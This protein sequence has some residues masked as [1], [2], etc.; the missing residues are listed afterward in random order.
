MS[1]TWWP[2]Y[3]L[4]L[5]ICKDDPAINTINKVLEE[6]GDLPLED[7]YFREDSEFSD[8]KGAIVCRDSEES[9]LTFH[10]L[11]GGSMEP[12]W[13]LVIPSVHGPGPFEGVYTEESLVSEFRERIGEYLPE[14]FDYLGHIGM[15]SYC[16]FC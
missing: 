6:K 12:S 13:M 1:R 2:E 11:A 9:G 7:V 4:G 8:K 3:G 10:P 16:I 5:V 15:Y 14:D